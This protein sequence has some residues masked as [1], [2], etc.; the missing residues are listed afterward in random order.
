MNAE[1]ISKDQSWQDQT[2]TYWFRADLSELDLIGDMVGV[3]ECG[4]GTV[5]AVDFEGYRI[6]HIGVAQKILAACI[7]TDEMRAQ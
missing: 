6:E 1:F 3:V 5:D 2:I 4:D 7:V